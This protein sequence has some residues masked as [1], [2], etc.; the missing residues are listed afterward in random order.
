MAT[1][2]NEESGQTA[3]EVLLITA[4]LLALVSFLAALSGS[5]FKDL[6]NT[7]SNKM[8]YWRNETIRRLAG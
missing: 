8:N 4:T 5:W 3:L 7:T 2:F 6:K 1:L